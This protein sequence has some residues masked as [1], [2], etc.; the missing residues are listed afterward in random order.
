MAHELK[1]KADNPPLPVDEIVR[2]LRALFA[3]VQV[4]VE[5]ASRE[6][7]ANARY[8]VRAGDFSLIVPNITAIIRPA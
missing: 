5:R 7:E 1:P 6:L 3:H 8:M 2:R 4:D